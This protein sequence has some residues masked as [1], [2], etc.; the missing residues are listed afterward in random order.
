[1]RRAQKTGDYIREEV[2]INGNIAIQIDSVTDG[3]VGGEVGE[4]FQFFEIEGLEVFCSEGGDIGAE[5]GERSL[6][7][8][9]GDAHTSEKAEGAVVCT[10]D[11]QFPGDLDFPEMGEEIVGEI[12]VAVVRESEDEG[13][14]R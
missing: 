14:L 12:L 1:M 3:R 10:D 9:A 11:G 13:A 2:G 7:A 4:E 8:E 6:E 5:L